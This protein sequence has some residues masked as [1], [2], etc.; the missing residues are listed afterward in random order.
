MMERKEYEITKEDAV[1]LGPEIIKAAHERRKKVLGDGV[2]QQVDELLRVKVIH[3]NQ[4]SDSQKQIDII[5]G[6]LL[7][8]EEGKFTVD[9]ECRIVFNVPDPVQP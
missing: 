5:N 2:I 8:I 4:I 6:K 3:Q 9:R 7:L 1:A